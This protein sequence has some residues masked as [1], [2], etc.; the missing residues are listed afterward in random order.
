M[1]PP[2]GDGGS[3]VPIDRPILEF[4]Q[5]RFI[6]TNQVEE[7][8]ITDSNG[9]LKLR[10]TFAQPYYPA[11]VDEATLAVRWYTN[12]DF[13]IHYREVHADSVWECQWDRH[14]NP[15]NTRD[16][17]HPPPT[18]PTLGENAAWPAD[19]RDVLTLVL[20]EIEQ[21]F[22]TLWDE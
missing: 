1:V 12:D 6:A 10:I 13:K 19:Y 5:T 15:H 7:A 16:H 21:R 14:P 4:L 17:F 11:S 8:V 3:P 22:T 18:A 9:H 20:D 2:T